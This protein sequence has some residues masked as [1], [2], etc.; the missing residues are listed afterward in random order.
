[1][2]LTHPNMLIA[3]HWRVAS[4]LEP[5][6][7]MTQQTGRWTAPTGERADDPRDQ[8]QKTQIDPVKIRVICNQAAFAKGFDTSQ[9]RL[10]ARAPANRQKA[11]VQG[12]RQ[13]L[14]LAAHAAQIVP[15]HRRQHSLTPRILRGASAPR[16]QTTDP[17]QCPKPVRLPTT[18]LCSV[19]RRARYACEFDLSQREGKQ[20]RRLEPATVRNCSALMPARCSAGQPASMTRSSPPRVSCA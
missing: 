12:A 17:F 10:M 4:W 6:T 2:R 1:M 18:A 14:E 11:H 9:K 13:V 20:L 15:R 3:W 19:I 5:R 16:P 7:A 8:T